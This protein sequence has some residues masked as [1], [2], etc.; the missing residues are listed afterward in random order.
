MYSVAAIQYVEAE[1]LFAIAGQ[2]TEEKRQI[3]L[4]II[5]QAEEKIEESNETA[6]EADKIIEGGSK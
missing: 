4:E 3:A 5:R 6:I 2:Q 1:A